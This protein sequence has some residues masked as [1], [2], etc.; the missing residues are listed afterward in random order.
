MTS[1][2]PFTWLA[3]RFDDDGDVGVLGSFLIDDGLLGGELPDGGLT[4]DRLVTHL[5]DR[6]ATQAVL[7]AAPGALAA[8]LA[9]YPSQAP[10]P[11]R[12]PAADYLDDTDVVPATPADEAEIRRLERRHYMKD[13]RPR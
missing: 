10:E 1:G 9:E 8:Y 3:E 6:G 7:D 4:L 13:G 2:V 5:R 11:S 12:E